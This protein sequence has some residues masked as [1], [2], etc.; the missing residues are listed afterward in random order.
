MNYETN[1]KISS[2][3]Y[4]AEDDRP[5]EKILLKGR[6]SLSDAEL[7]AILIS[8]GTREESAVDLAKKVLMLASNNIN[9]LAKFSVNDL[10]KVKGIGK[11]KA[12]T[13][14]AALE[15]GRR[16]KSE[17]VFERK[18]V[19]TSKDIF[20]FFS[21]IL[22]DYQH[23]EFWILLLNRSNKII[24]SKKVSEGGVSGTVADPRIIF[25]YAVEELASSIALCHNH[26]S[27]NVKPSE[28]DMKLTQKLKNAGAF[29]DIHVIDHLIIGDR[30]YYSFNDE[31]A[32]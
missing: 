21:P 8:T 25:K 19:L 32:M 4:W 5:R 2:I 31:G 3:K 23:E 26:P 7:L 22:S 6:A 15:L 27:G 30:K 14:I 29:F 16:K 24:G 13:I 1:S 9:E 28:E 17:M 11:A 20:D 18:Q 12:L 10:Q